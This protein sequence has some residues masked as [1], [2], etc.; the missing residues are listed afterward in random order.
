MF[1]TPPTRVP[2]RNRPKVTAV[3]AQMTRNFGCNKLGSKATLYYHSQ[4]KRTRSKKTL[5][6]FHRRLRRVNQMCID[7][8]EVTKATV[9][10]HG[11]LAQKSRIGE[12]TDTGRA[13]S[14]RPVSSFFFVCT[15]SV[16]TR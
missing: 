4:I 6:S 13:I 1:K 16:Y 2:D 14:A 11:I 7:I 8:S 10:R 5:A 15:V 9:T 3:D 12:D